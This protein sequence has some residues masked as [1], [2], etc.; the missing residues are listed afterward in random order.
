MRRRNLFLLAGL[1]A[2]LAF[3]A[4]SSPLFADPPKLWVVNCDYGDGVVASYKT[5]DPSEIPNGISYCHAGGGQVRGVEV[6]H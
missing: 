1:S 2:S 4:G 5:Q 3:L 6:V